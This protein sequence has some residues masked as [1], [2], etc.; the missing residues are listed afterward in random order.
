MT[1]TQKLCPY[2]VLW[3]LGNPEG[4]MV[5]LNTKRVPCLTGYRA[6]HTA[7][8]TKGKL[9]MVWA[10]VWVSLEYQ[11]VN[12][13]DD[14]M[15]KAVDSIDGVLAEKAA[16][17]LGLVPEEARVPGSFRLRKGYPRPDALSSLLGCCYWATEQ[18]VAV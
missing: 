10:Q 13:L 12:D 7:H 11:S 1:T 3:T 18:E 14:A 8:L 9:P 15:D 17:L 5:D 2:T 4:W 16:L 6:L